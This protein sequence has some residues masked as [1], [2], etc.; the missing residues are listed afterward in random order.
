[1]PHARYDHPNA[2]PSSAKTGENENKFHRF[3]PIDYAR[4]DHP[5]AGLSSA[6]TGENEKIVRNQQNVFKVLLI[7]LNQ[8]T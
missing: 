7:K 2:G 8:L 4:Y 1:M 3:W 6:K 5:T